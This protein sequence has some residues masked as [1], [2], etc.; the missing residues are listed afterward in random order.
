[1]RPG[2]RAGAAPLF[3][4]IPLDGAWQSWIASNHLPTSPENSEKAVLV[5]VERRGAE[6]GLLDADE[7][8][9]ELASLAATAGIEV[10]AS[11]IQAIKRPHPKTLIGSGKIDEIRQL[12]ESL[13]AKVV[14]FDDELTPVQQRNLEQLFCVKVV[15]RTQLILDIFAMR[16]TTQ[17]GKLQVELAQL[18]YLM[19]RLTRQWLHL[20]R[21]RGGVGTRGPGETQL[22]VDRRLARERVAMLRRR[23]K[24][25]SR[26]RALHRAKRASVPYPTVALVGYT[27][28]GKSTLMNRLTDAGVLVENKLFAT[29]DPTVRLLRLPEGGVALLVDTVGFIHKLPH[30][31]VDAFKS[32]LEEVSN[33]CLLLH[34]VDGSHDRAEEHLEVVNCVLDELDAGGTPRV[35]VFN[36]ADRVAGER[37]LPRV[38]GASCEISA[39]TGDGIDVLLGQIA[40]LLA[41]QQEKVEVRI[42]IGRADLMAALHRGGRVV[43]EVLEGDQEKY[44]VTAFVSPAVAGRI[45]KELAGSC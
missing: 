10:V 16:A 40:T 37:R 19:P 22:E 36:K 30:G 17:E 25:V 3:P 38:E 18:Q 34:V 44:R 23:L 24:Q 12:V 27:N 31:F 28:A 29:L 6:A 8:L 43:E 39:K 11:A 35:T 7:S 20:S 26:T 4:T 14:L 9:R 21:Q 33:A 45:R 15:D 41:S 42:P 1:M 5:A 32:T 13:E 2:P